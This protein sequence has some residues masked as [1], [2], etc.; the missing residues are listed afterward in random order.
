MSSSDSGQVL[1]DW[2]FGEGEN[3]YE[4]I[5]A[6]GYWEVHAVAEAL[7]PYLSTRRNK[8][9]YFKARGENNRGTEVLENSVASTERAH[10]AFNEALNLMRDHYK[11]GDDERDSSDS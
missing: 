5:G 2:V 3:D 6:L 8:L 7:K 11:A 4:A 1:I 10:A 9:D